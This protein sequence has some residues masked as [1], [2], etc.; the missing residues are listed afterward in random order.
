MG[1]Y[2]NSYVHYVSD[3]TLRN[4]SNNINYDMNSSSDDIANGNDCDISMYGFSCS[5]RICSHVRLL[6]LLIRTFSKGHCD[7]NVRSS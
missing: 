1:S 5:P 7:K 3:E 4:V 2:G 6:L